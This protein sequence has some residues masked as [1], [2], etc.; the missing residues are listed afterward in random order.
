MSPFFFVSR[1]SPVYLERADFGSLPGD[2]ANT[3]V[4]ASQ[5]VLHV[6]GALTA[7]ASPHLRRLFALASSTMGPPATL[8]LLESRASSAVELLHDIPCCYRN[9]HEFSFRALVFTTG[10]G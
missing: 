4:A 5:R 6:D 10:T 1:P 8:S 9:P 3:I 2:A 7:A